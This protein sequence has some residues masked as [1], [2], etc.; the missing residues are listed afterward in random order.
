MTRIC[1]IDAHPDAADHLCH[2]LADAY[3]Q[4]ARKAGH[5]IE[6]IDLAQLEFGFLEKVSD[7]DIAPP[8]PVLSEREKIARADHVCLVFPLWLGNMPARAKAFL[9]LAAC[10]NFFLAAANSSRNW[11]KQMMKGKS[12]RTIIT[13]GMP[14]PVYSLVFDAGALKALERGLFGI[15]GFK[16][17]RHT[18]LGGVEQAGD[19]ARQKWF[20]KI[21]LLGQ[22]AD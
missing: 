18:I 2:A 11:P 13:M 3:E 7:F 16:P 12:A 19:E 4:G 6:R 20:R 1:L 9:E 5:D 8:E 14:G 15:S 10:G 17:V 21:D 22:R